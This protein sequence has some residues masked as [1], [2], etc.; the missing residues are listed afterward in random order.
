MSLKEL[1]KNKHTEAEH[2]PFMKLVLKNQI[3]KAD[4][5]TF[6]FNKMQWYGAIETRARAAGLLDDLP[7]IERT[8]GLYLDYRTL[9]PTSRYF[10]KWSTV[11]YC[12]YIMNLSNTDSVLAHLYVWHMGDLYGGQMIKKILADFPHN[13]LE[14]ADPE[15]LK[16][17]IRKKLHTGLAEEANNAFDWAIRLMN[18]IVPGPIA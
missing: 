14:F 1:T 6:I 9:C 13:H 7:G 18:D 17:N 8:Y 16:A 3:P 10:Q 12:D 15:L 11:E 5:A 2:T 4:W